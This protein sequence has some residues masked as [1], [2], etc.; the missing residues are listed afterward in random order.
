MARF[1]RFGH[2][3]GWFAALPD[4]DGSLAVAALFGPSVQSVPHPSGRPWLIGRWDEADMV[5]ATVG[6]A[7]LA[8]LGTTSVSAAELTRWAARVRDVRELDRLGAGTAG[9]THLLATVDGQVRAQGSV[10]GV[11]RV[12]HARLGPLTLAADRA[13][14]LA[15]LTNATVDERRLALRLLHPGLP[16][17]LSELTMWPGISALPAD[18][19]LH[20]RPTGEGSARRWWSAPEPA[21]TLAEGAVLLRAALRDAVAVRTAGG[22]QLSADMSGGLDSS[23]ILALAVR[24]PVSV[25]TLTTTTGDPADEDPLY[26]DRLAASLPGLQRQVATTEEL[27]LPYDGAFDPHPPTDEPDCGLELRA[28]L[29]EPARRFAGH[30]R[31][32]LTGHG[33]DDVLSCT[34]TYLHRLVRTNPRVGWEH[35]RGYRAL[36]R[37]RLG[38]CLAELSDRRGFGDW[39]ADQAEALA[40]PL[41]ATDAGLADWSLAFRLPSWAS[42]HAVDAVRTLLREAASCARPLARDRAQHY[43]IEAMRAAGHEFRLTAA[44]SRLAGLELAAPFLDDRVAEACLA[45]RTHERTTPW[46]YKPLLVEAMRGT[47][48]DPVLSRVTKSEGSAVEYQGLRAHRAD[49]VEMTRES[50]LGRLGLIDAAALRRACQGAFP[51]H[52]PPVALALTLSAERWLRDR[53]TAADDAA[54]RR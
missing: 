43:A 28:G 19:Y 51:S 25:S 6:R 41:P 18:S 52:L 34:P 9:S 8:L 17:P 15:E 45:V 35:L 21:R 44:A 39:L 48:P 53:E 11:R 10:T 14:L 4:H 46:R 40:E 22:G 54:T 36:G 13:D 5:I 26:A 50:R 47:L 1:V 12:F 49:L 27:P 38:R 24:G 33:G 16:F 2:G 32:H 20:L 7:S 31:L 30:S 29:T 23:A 37:W 3:E 42:A